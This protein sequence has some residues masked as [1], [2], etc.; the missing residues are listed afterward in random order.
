MQARAP[1]PSR[2]PGILDFGF[3]IWIEDKDKK[4]QKTVDLP[5]QSKIQNR[6]SKIDL[7]KP[8]LAGVIELEGTT[9]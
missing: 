6:K 3:W 5:L 9:R 8:P 1:Q 4:L 2:F 7:G